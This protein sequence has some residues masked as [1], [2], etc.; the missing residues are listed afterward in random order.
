MLYV[1][2]E[3]ALVPNFPCVQQSIG[4]LTIIEKKRLQ[5]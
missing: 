1:V 4:V 3:L 2:L 5:I